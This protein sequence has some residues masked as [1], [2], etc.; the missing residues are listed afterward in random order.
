MSTGEE[1]KYCEECRQIKPPTAE[2]CSKCSGCIR[3][4]F[5]HCALCANCVGGGNIGTYFWMVLGGSCLGGV[6]VVKVG[7]EVG[8]N[9]GLYLVFPGEGGFEGKVMMVLVG[10]AVVFRLM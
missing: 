8:G 7:V 4:H 1:Y 6:Y 5:R 9:L 2:H 3:D 10:L